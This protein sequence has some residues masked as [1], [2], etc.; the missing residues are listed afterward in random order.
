MHEHDI[1]SQWLV[2]AARC[3]R[4]NRWLQD[5]ASAA[6]CILI[7]A[8]LYQL[9]RI[10][11]VDPHVLTALRPLLA[12][13]ALSGLG[14]V[15][16]RSLRSVTPAQAA[17]AADQRA[18]LKDELGSAWWFAHHTLR[19][20]MIDLLV[21]SAAQTVQ[22]L[23]PRKLFPLAW[24]RTF[25]IAIAVA[26]IVVALGSLP[27]RSTA[28]AASAPDEDP[29]AA[30][31]AK[32]PA[33]AFE[34]D[35]ASA[36]SERELSAANERLDA[37]VRD[38]A[39]DVSAE[40]VAQALGGRDARSAA[41]LVEAI[42]R[43]QAAA[44]SEHGRAARPQ[45]EQMSDALAQGIVERLQQLSN[46]DESAPQAAPQLEDA[47]QATQRLQRE[48][49]EEMEGVQRSQPG[50][51]STREQELNTR[52]RAISRNS[53]GGREMVRGQAE[54][55]PD[56][57]RTSVGGGGAMGRRVGVSQAGGGNGEQPRTNAPNEEADPVLGKKTRRLAV[58]LQTIK[59]EQA[60]DEDRSGTEDAFY[61]ATQAQA[62]KL[63]YEA[64]KP[65]RRASSEQSVESR[66]MPMA[67]RDA[68]KQYM[69]EQHRRE[70]R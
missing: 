62:S 31:S 6:C 55:T 14:W 57:G 67:Y 61:A 10:A 50:E 3:M 9:M 46:T 19:S 28:S 7:A 36:A 22:R 5:A 33:P 2:R 35:T 64:V 51:Q 12:L 45:S 53:T 4:I 25:F 1:L 70:Q 18:N 27:P 16:W 69:L 15:I 17:A 60:D 13:F 20:P 58:P 52:L 44:Q 26:V 48:L 49:R 59:V 54:A 66:R 37:L 40:A 38:L 39:G 29:T 23:E 21:K 63:D 65:N 42:R 47:E 68:V 30:R 8:A 56:A 24:P 34:H 32:R 11:A 43:R 41:L